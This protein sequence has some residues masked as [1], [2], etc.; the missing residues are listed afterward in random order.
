MS[1]RGVAWGAGPTLAMGS[2]GAVPYVKDEDDDRVA[3]APREASPAFPAATEDRSGAR[4]RRHPS[5]VSE[6]PA[7]I[8]PY[9]LL[10][11][12]GLTA[13]GQAYRA[14]HLEQNREVALHVLEREDDAEG[15]LARALPL[16][17]AKCA[18]LSHQNVIGLEDYGREG[19]EGRYYLVT[20][21]LEGTSLAAQLDDLGKLSLLRTLSVALQIGRALRAAHKLGIVHGS[22]SPANVRLVV[23]EQGEIARVVGF[24]SAMFGPRP[25]RASPAPASYEAPEC[26][27]GAEPDVRSDVFALGSLVFRMLTGRVPA[28]QPGQPAPRLAT[29][30]EEPIPR[31]LEQL[32]AHCLEPAPEERL[33]DLVVLMAA[34]REI[35]QRVNER[36]VA[37]G[38]PPIA[39]VDS[40][41]P[42]PDGESSGS[43]F[44]VDQQGRRGGAAWILASLTVALAAVWLLWEAS[45][46]VRPPQQGMREAGTHSVP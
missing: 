43:L 18:Q 11:P 45:N 40:S 12:I 9:Q 21:P 30:S 15:S 13:Y 4:S 2:A 24:G 27:T 17:V 31:E 16:A 28:V 33:A 26:A 35:A 22:L 5:P 39:L 42:P 10:S 44:V 1:R 46:R 8:E 20:A 25:R 37:E 23:S 38:Q 29:W 32:V 19:H 34:L 36:E 7:A 6:P 3:A 41:A 14:R